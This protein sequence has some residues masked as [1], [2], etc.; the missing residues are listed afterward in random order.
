[1]RRL[2]TLVLVILALTFAASAQTATGTITGN[3]TDGTGAI[4]PGAKVTIEN[5]NTGVKQT[6]LVN[7]NGSFLQSYLNPGS[8]KV[9]VEQAGFDKHVT[10]N[11]KVSV[12]QTIELEIALKVGEVSTA[13]EVSANTA[14]LA[15]T[16]STVSTVISSKA[17][18]DLPLNGRNAFGLATLVPGVFPGGGSTPWISGGRNASS[19]ITIDGTS[20]IVPENNVS[21]QD[22]GYTPI[23]DTVEEL[24]VITNALQAEFGRT[25]GGVI[26]IATRSG[27]NALHGSVFEFLRNSKLDA[28]SWTNNR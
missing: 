15:T 11:I 10:S 14:Q 25:G 26:A 2:V 20:V 6:T 28:N 19:E 23:V 21:I 8:Y 27:T 13:V 17:M 9:T 1:M 4:V 7:G 3:V 22:T 18:L 12:Q 24:V 16:N 5:Q